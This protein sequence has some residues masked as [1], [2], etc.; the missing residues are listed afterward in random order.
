M[1][2]L[3][4]S[5][6]GAHDTQGVL[7]NCKITYGI[8]FAASRK[9]GGSECKAFKTKTEILLFPSIIPMLFPVFRRSQ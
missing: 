8:G 2:T 4:S 6:G 9:E 5:H 7:L 3:G 1:G